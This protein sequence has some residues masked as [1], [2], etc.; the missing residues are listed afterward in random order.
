MKDTPIE[1]LY[2]AF[3]SILCGAK[4]IVEVNKLV[5]S[6]PGL[7]QAFGRNR[8]AEQS[9]IQE[10]LNA[11]SG[12]NVEQ[13]EVAMNEIYCQHSQGYKHDYEQQIQLLD[14]DMTGQPCSS[15]LHLPLRAILPA[16]AIAPGPQVGRVLASHYE[17]IVVERVFA[18]KVQ[19]NTALQPLI[20]E[21]EKT[22]SVE[23]SPPKRS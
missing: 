21:A 6:D 22:L 7:Q 17:E 4:G 23:Q 14:V 1:K 9:V 8:C 12:N 3:I 15:K 10:M 20:E 2:D 18:G 11:S 19:L 13:M 16:S 5:R